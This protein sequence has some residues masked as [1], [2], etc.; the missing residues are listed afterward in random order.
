MLERRV[1]G[2]FLGEILRLVLLKLHQGHDGSICIPNA[3]K[4]NHSS[5]S[6]DRS[7]ELPPL[8]RR[9]AVDSSVLSINESDTSPELMVVKRTL[10]S[11]FGL[12]HATRKECKALKILV[13]AI[14]KRAVR[15]S[16]VAL[17]AIILSSDRLLSDV[18]NDVGVDGSL[19]EHS[20][21]FEEYLRRALRKID[22]ISEAGER[23]LT[24]RH[25]EDG[26]G[27]GAALA[28]LMAQREKEL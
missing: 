2:L 5:V 4:S 13:H 7:D 6:R 23:K 1:S 15:L 8:F 16:A 11:S 20:P 28:A 26:S 25:C 12:S 3:V 10:A 9:P 14:G 22:E 27:L 21:G 19:A 18:K 17:V 24:R